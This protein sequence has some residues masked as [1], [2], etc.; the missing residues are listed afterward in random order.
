M[1]WVNTPTK[2]YHCSGDRWYGK[3]KSGSYM[4]EACG[5]G[6]RRPS[7][8]RQ[9]LQLIGR[10]VPVNGPVTCA[11]PSGSRLAAHESGLG[12]ATTTALDDDDAVPGDD[13]LL[14][15]GSGYG[16]AVAAIDGHDQKS[17]VGLMLD[18]PQSSGAQSGCWPRRDG[19][20]D[21][22]QSQIVQIVAETLQLFGAAD[23]AGAVRIQDHFGDALGPDMRGQHHLICTGVQQF[24]LGGRRFARAQ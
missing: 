18:L 14:R 23:H 11:T 17:P 3:T 5:E 12:A 8:S 1:V 24:A 9:G 4:T 20:H 10:P 2:V 22:V 15:V 16:A 6:R 21:Q 19:H 7:G 13:R